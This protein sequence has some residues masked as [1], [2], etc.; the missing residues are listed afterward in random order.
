MSLR[1]ELSR[2]GVPVQWF[3]SENELCQGGRYQMMLRGNIAEMHIRN[4]QPEDVGEYSCVFGEQKTTAE[5]NVRGI[6]HFIPLLIW[7]FSVL[8]FSR[9]SCFFLNQRQHP[10]TLRR[11]WRAKL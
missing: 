1:C 5:V 7:L 6:Q 2:T 9:F 10:C 4:I 8:K 3:K 11:S